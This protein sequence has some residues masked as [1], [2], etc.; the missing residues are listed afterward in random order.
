MGCDRCVQ[1]HCGLAFGSI[2]EVSAHFI[3]MGKET[4]QEERMPEVQTSVKSIGSLLQICKDNGVK[5]GGQACETI[6]SCKTICCK[7]TATLSKA[8][9]AASLASTKAEDLLIP[10]KRQTFL[11]QL[12]QMLRH[13]DGDSVFP[14]NVSRAADSLLTAIQDEIVKTPYGF[15]GPCCGALVAAHR[16]ALG[17]DSYY[18]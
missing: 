13:A 10:E 18:Q 5:L 4:L 17:I 2:V 11:D 15:S 12:M 6:D 14:E 1:L 9:F 8:G 3:S 7:I 16:Q